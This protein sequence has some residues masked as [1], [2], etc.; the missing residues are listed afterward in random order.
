MLLR[1]L[2]ARSYISIFRI[3]MNAYKR[4]LLLTFIGPLPIIAILGANLYLYD[5][6]QL[7]HKPIFRPNTFFSDM[8]VAAQGIISLYDFDSYILGTSQLENT[9]AKDA[10]ATLGG[11][12]VNISMSSSSYEERAAVLKHIFATKG[13][14]DILYTLDF[15]VVPRRMQKISQFLYNG[16]SLD[17]WKFYMNARFLSCSIIWSSQISCVGEFG[18]L[19]DSIVKWIHKE[20]YYGKYGGIENWIKYSDKSS[21]KRLLQEIETATTTTISPN[22]QNLIQADITTNILQLIKAHKETRFHLVIPTLSRLSYKVNGSFPMFKTTLKWLVKELETL[23]NATLYGFDDLEYA[24][25][26]KNYKDLGHYNIDM[27]Q[28][29]LDSIKQRQHII[30]AD[31][32][33]AYLQTMENRIAQY[34]E[35]QIIQ[36][37]NNA[38]ENQQ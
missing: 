27:N 17:D 15:L 21:L 24:D 9:L 36:T 7:F 38:I 25:D 35:T 8:R 5:P 16:T 12:W 31:N 1:E 22:D 37:L 13:A 30:T 32:V 26:I 34:D 11:K 33:D 4:Y 19:N 28:L 14:K 2:T 18:D 29:H 3:F 10:K 23:P 20:K 6:V